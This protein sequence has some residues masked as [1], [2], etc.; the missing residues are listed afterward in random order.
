[1]SK[2][3]NSTMHPYRGRVDPEHEGG[4]AHRTKKVGLLYW[5]SRVTGRLCAKEEF[6]LW[7]CFE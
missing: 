2:G 6:L 1:M 5:V 4:C 3:I 7:Y